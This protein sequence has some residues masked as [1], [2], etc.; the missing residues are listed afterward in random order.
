MSL[1]PIHVLAKPEGPICNLDCK[2]C[3]YLEKE[4]LY[5]NTFQWAMP[6]DVLESFIAQYIEQQS[7]EE[8]FFAWQ[9][10]EP[11]LQGIDFF[12]EIVVLQS[13]H[14][15]GKRVHNT[16]QNSRP[17]AFCSMIPGGEFL[18]ENQFLV[19][20]SIGGPENVHDAYPVNSNFAVSKPW[21]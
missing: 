8:I 18:A 21:R 12:R 16:F 7:T 14:A 10:D 3:F 15:N 20:V 5:P 2:Y 17:M 1:L 13:K 19:G 6:L 9:G 4:L 11:T